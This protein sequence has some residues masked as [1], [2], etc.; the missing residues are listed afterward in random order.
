[1][2]E[3]IDKIILKK[4]NMKKSNITDS[5]CEKVNKTLDQLS[6]KELRA[7]KLIKFKLAVVVACTCLGISGTVMAAANY[8]QEHMLSMTEE[9]KKTL[10]DTVQKSS[11][12]IDT[13]S[14]NFYEEEKERFEK[15]QSAYLS[16][17]IFPQ[18]D[19]P[20][21][22]NVD[23]VTE[24]M[25]AFAIEESMF[26]FPK[27]ILTDEE[28]LEVI[29]FYYKRDYSL[30]ENQVDRSLATYDIDENIKKDAI[31]KSLLYIN[32]LYGVDAKDYQM[33]IE[34]DPNNVYRLQFSSDDFGTYSILYD[35]VEKKIAEIKYCSN[36][37]VQSESIMIDNKFFTEKGIQILE[38]INT[39]NDYG[40]ITEIYCDYNTLDKKRLERNIVS[41]I[42][43]L[44]NGN[45]YVAKYNFAIERMTN[46]FIVPYKYYQ[47]T[48]DD[49]TGKREKRGI[50]RERINV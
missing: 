26:V 31:D 50:Q 28:I 46:L 20:I 7:S 32:N 43:K 29:N 22:E 24:E 49:N 3:N 8:L 10:I 17:G 33:S 45:C 5:Y 16:E 30:Q 47:K 35:L 44:S 42:F 37:E 6:E 34:A 27:R 23:L 13:Y 19:L 1:M 39:I 41:Y 18:N 14:R 9:D 15:F 4:I 12:D 40:D 21:V 2:K 38:S 48:I 11:A 36:A 25:L